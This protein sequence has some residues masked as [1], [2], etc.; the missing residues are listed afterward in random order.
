MEIVF[1]ALMAL[2]FTLCSTSGGPART[3]QTALRGTFPNVGTRGR[4]VVRP[5]GWRGATV[6]QQHGL[7]HAD[8][9]VAALDTAC[10]YAALTVLEGLHRLASRPPRAS[11]AAAATASW[12]SD[13]RKHVA[14]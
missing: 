12:M 1:V 3:S 7:L 9:V 14:S 4:P 10:G 8:V 6:S 2:V 13:R 5:L 11:A